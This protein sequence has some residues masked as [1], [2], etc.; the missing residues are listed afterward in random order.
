MELS[1][2]LLSPENFLAFVSV[3]VKNFEKVW[4]SVIFISY[5]SKFYYD[6]RSLYIL[7]CCNAAFFVLIWEWDM[8]LFTDPFCVS[9]NRYPYNS[10]MLLNNSL[11]FSK[12]FLLYEYN[13]EYEYNMNTKHNIFSKKTLILDKMYK[14][15]YIEPQT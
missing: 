10:R 4:R 5:V 15:I 2:P 6:I 13:T 11:L 7:T 9:P 12:L 8:L 14:N 1:H 3:S